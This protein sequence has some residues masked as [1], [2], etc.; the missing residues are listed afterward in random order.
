MTN[1]T[2]LFDF[3]PERKGSDS[4][5]WRRYHDQDILPL[6]V[7]DMDF[8]APEPVL[9]AVKQRLEHGVLGYA[10]PWPSLLEGVAEGIARDHG[11]RIDPDWI[12]WL[13]GVVPGFNLACQLAGEPGAGILCFPPIYPPMLHAPSNGARKLVRCDLVQMGG[14]WKIDW[15]ALSQSDHANTRMLMLCNPHNPVGRVWS[16]DELSRLAELAEHHDWLICSDDIH[17]GLVLDTTTSYH[18]I[19]ALDES[20]ARRSIT[21]M[22]PSKTWNVPGLASAF[23]IIPDPQL[24]RRYQRVGQGINSTPN[25]L[26]LVATEAAYRH[27]DPWRQAL[28]GYLRENAHL[29]ETTINDTGI[30][31]TTHVEATYLAWIDCRS[32]NI[33]HPQHFFERHG[34]GLSNG[35]DFGLEGFVRLNFGCSRSVLQEA[36]TRIQTALTKHN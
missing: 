18:P 32:L 17:C 27:G 30:L 12:V 22:A 29:V 20:I 24:R 21:L 15:E 36:L 7:A 9:T 2:H 10:N 26:G 28:L 31:H 14:H 34:V 5:K 23:A 11:W 25:L 16:Q 4:L 19:A 13:P 1:L 35:A 6:W 8:A 3:P 33:A